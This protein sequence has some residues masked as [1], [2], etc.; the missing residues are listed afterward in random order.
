MKFSKECSWTGRLVP[1]LRQNLESDMYRLEHFGQ[2]SLA[3]AM[4]THRVPQVT[5]WCRICPMKTH[6]KTTVTCQ[7][8]WLSLDLLDQQPWSS[9]SGRSL[10]DSC[11]NRWVNPI[12]I[13]MRLLTPAQAPDRRLHCGCPNTLHSLQQQVKHWNFFLMGVT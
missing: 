7:Y 4:E 3:S 11:L 10:Q 1:H 13:S 6:A 2:L 8:V 12:D 5:C 9:N